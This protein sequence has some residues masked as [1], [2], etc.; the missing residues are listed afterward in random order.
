MVEKESGLP[1]P[2]GG[3]V[4]KRSLGAATIAAIESALRD[5]VASS[6][7]NP[8]S[9][10]HY[11]HEH[12]QEMNEE[13]CSAHI[14]LYVNDFSSDLGD[15]GSRPLSAFWTGRKRRDHPC[16]HGAA[17]WLIPLLQI[18]LIL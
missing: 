17:L 16:F 2:L 18:M 1:I 8:A 4:A 14:G 3:I 6:G 5:G 7:A 9:A 11:I 10:A 15:E 12:A 13:V